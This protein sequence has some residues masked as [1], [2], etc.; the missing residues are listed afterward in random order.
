MKSKTTTKF[1]LI[2]V[3]LGFAAYLLYPT[4]KFSSLT[5]EQKDVME[6]D[7]KTEFLNLMS[8]ETI[9]I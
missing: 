6:L 5:Q 3:V 2:L 1:I 8:K 7:N 4:Y 9:I